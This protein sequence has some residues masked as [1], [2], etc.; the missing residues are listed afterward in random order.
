M[1]YSHQQSDN[2][3]IFHWVWQ[4]KEIVGSTNDEVKKLANENNPIVISAKYQKEGRGRR[5]NS[6]QSIEGNLY[7]SYSQEIPLNELSRYVCIVGLALAKTIKTQS[8]NINVKIKWPNDIYINNQKLAG[9]LFENIKENLW[10]IGIG[11]NIVKAPDLD[12]KISYKATSLKDN[13]INLDRTEFLFYY[14]ENF[15]KEIV[16]YRNYG[17][18]KIKEQWLEYAL[19]LGETVIIKNEKITKEGI[20]SNIDDNGYLILKKDKDE[21]RIIAGELFI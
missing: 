16:Q 4:D 1:L 14:L 11:V 20:F 6:W 13:S 5:G 21:E 10:V 3:K 9:I 12:D 15:K 18:S 2:K 19:N 7:F 17:F 8:Q